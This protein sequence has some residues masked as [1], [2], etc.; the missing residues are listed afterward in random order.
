MLALPFIPTSQ[1]ESFVPIATIAGV[2]AVTIGWVCMEVVGERLMRPV[3]R[4]V[5]AIEHDE[6]GDQRLPELARQTPSEV[7]PL[8]YGL[9]VTHANLRRIVRQLERDRAE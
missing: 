8:L 5:R 7:A 6:I 9:H 4:L 1:W 2:V 3:R